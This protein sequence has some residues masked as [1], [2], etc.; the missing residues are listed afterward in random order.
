MVAFKER[1]KDF[2]NCDQRNTSFALFA[3]VV[4]PKI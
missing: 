4:C 2:K 1:K 3:E